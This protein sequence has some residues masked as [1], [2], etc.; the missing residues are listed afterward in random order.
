MQRGTVVGAVVPMPLV[1]SSKRRRTHTLTHTDTQVAGARTRQVT[2]AQLAVAQA[3]LGVTQAHLVHLYAESKGVH[4]ASGPILSGLPDEVFGL[5]IAACSGAAGVPLFDTVKRLVCSR[6]LQ[7][8]IHRLKPLVG[9]HSLNLLQS[10]THGRWDA[11]LLFEGRLTTAEMAQAKKGGVLSIDARQS[12]TCAN[13]WAALTS[14][15][16]KRV[17]PELLGVGC[18]LQMLN[19]QGVPLDGTWAATFGKAAVCS[20]LLRELLLGDCSLRGPLPKLSLPA[21]QRLELGGNN[22]LTGGLEP[23]RG[24]TGLKVLDLAGNEFYPRAG[25]QLTGG[26]EPLRGCTGLQTLSLSSNLLTGGLEPL[27]DCTALRYLSLQNNHFTGGLEPLRW[28]TSLRTLDGRA[29]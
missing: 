8:Q 11:V 22:Q 24:C 18:L 2:P 3:H 26:L 25:N 10:L 7:Q 5:V 9:V 23:L 13:P 19:L 27:Q 17:V 4:E 16:A 20:A 29:I 14:P 6:A 15:V 12:R 28:C 21:L 1:D